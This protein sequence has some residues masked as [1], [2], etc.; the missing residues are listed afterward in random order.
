MNKRRKESV[1]KLVLHKI[2]VGKTRIDQV[3]QGFF[4][5]RYRTRSIPSEKTY[6]RKVKHKR[7]NN[8]KL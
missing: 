4:D 5:G 2:E 6:T 7:I 8:D 3:E 1:D